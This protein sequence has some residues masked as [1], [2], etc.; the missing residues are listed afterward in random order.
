MRFIL[1]LLLTVTTVVLQEQQ[2]SGVVKDESGT[3]LSGALHL[4]VIGFPYSKTI[5]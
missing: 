5:N 1:V 2:I 4:A 3:S